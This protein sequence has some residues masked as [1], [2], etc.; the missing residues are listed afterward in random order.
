MPYDTY[1]K[2]IGGMKRG[3]GYSGAKGFKAVKHSDRGERKGK[4]GK[5]DKR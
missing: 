5:S 3:Y 4:Q 1:G 2:K